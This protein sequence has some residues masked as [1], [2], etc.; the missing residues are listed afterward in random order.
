M[1]S[2][3]KIPQVAALPIMPLQDMEMCEAPA[4]SQIVQRG[5]QL[6]DAVN[7]QNLFHSWGDSGT[8]LRRYKLWWRPIC[9]DEL[10]KAAQWSKKDTLSKWDKLQRIDRQYVL[11]YR[12]TRYVN[13]AGYVRMLMFSA[14][15]YE[16]WWVIL[17]NHD[18]SRERIWDELSSELNF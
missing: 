17:L 2:K 4:W 16:A 18:E 8:S 10:Q 15:R 11:R 12:G 1:I 14:R 3:K 13:R 5:T 9:D 6:T 7:I